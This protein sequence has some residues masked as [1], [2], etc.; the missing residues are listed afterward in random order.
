[1]PDDW[2][3]IP[4]PDWAAFNLAPNADAICQLAMKPSTK[5]AG[6]SLQTVPP[7]VLGYLMSLETNDPAELCVHVV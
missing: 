4:A 1:M 2:K 3:G 6:R 5:F 7:S